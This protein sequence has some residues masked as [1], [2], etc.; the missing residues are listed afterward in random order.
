M[1]TYR[2]KVTSGLGFEAD[3]E[4]ELPHDDAARTWADEVADELAEDGV[5]LTTAELTCGDRVLA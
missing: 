5:R 1:K 3:F 2:F 4:A